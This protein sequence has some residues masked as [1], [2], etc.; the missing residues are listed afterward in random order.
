MMMC[1]IAEKSE[2]INNRR[3]KLVIAFALLAIGLIISFGSWNGIL[4]WQGDDRGKVHVTYVVPRERVLFPTS[5]ELFEVP[6]Y[7]LMR[8]MLGVFIT[9]IGITIVASPLWKRLVKESASNNF[10]SM[11]YSKVNDG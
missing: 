9:T 10:I 11:D 3:A 6:D 5:F 2:R 7:L 8:L 4:A 1:M